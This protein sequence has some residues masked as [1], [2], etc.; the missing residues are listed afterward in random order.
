MKYM[1][2]ISLLFI[3]ACKQTSIKTV[4]ANCEKSAA[5]TAV[6]M[7]LI[8]RAT[9]C[10]IIDFNAYSSRVH[11]CDCNIFVEDKDLPVHLLCDEA[12]FCSFPYL[13]R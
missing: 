9:S 1:I 11:S 10:K 4:K 5:D 3:T 7:S 8:L 12:G 13:G 6:N 2:L